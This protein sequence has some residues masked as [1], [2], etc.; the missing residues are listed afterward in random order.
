MQ[1]VEGWAAAVSDRE[2]KNDTNRKE[3]KLRSP[4]VSSG[5]S[6]LFLSFSLFFSLMWFLSF[7]LL[8]QRPF[9]VHFTLLA[10]LFFVY[11]LSFSSS[12]SFSWVCVFVWAVCDCVR[13]PV[14]RAARE[15]ERERERK[16]EKERERRKLLLA[17]PIIRQMIASRLEPVAASS[18]QQPCYFWEREKRR[19]RKGEVTLEG[20]L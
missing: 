18:M 2:K 15:R 8:L 7:F 9:L 19:E 10:V 5:G 4:F 13:Q 20:D 6:M 11:F 3:Q 1:V 16:R 17:Q 14:T 12:S